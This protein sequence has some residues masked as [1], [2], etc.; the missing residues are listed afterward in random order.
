MESAHLD[1]LGVRVDEERVCRQRLLLR[2]AHQLL[3]LQNTVRTLRP[4]AAH[5]T[6][7]RGLLGLGVGYQH[8]GVQ[9][10]VVVLRPQRARAQAVGR[11]LAKPPAKKS[12]QLARC[13]DTQGKYSGWPESN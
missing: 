12:A 2:G 6:A 8:V 11:A 13:G 10:G 3:R 4:R 7:H 1:F 9:R 5:A